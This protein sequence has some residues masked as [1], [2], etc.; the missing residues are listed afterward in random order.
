MISYD[1]WHAGEE[2]AEAGWR[3]VSRI[4]MTQPLRDYIFARVLEMTSKWMFR[5]TTP[6]VVWQMTHDERMLSAS[7]ACLLLP[8]LVMELVGGIFADR[9]DRQQIMTV[10]CIGSLACNLVIAALA[11]AGSL[12]LPLL[13]GLTALYGGINAVSHAAS[14]TIVTAYVR[15]EDLSTAVSLNAVV[16]NVAGFVGPALA[17]GLI[18]WFGS[19]ASYLTCAVLTSAF[20]LLLRRIPP[21][22]GEGGG[23]HGT[24]LGA[25]RDGL[26]HVLS[27]QLLMWVFILHIGSIALTRPFVE[28]VPAIVHHAFNG[29]VRESGI[30][31]S[32]F[33]LGS[34]AG[35]LWLAGSATSS[36]RLAAI[37]LGAMPVFAGA[38]IG[39]VL[40]PT[41]LMALPFAFVAGFGMISRA[42]A[43]QSL[44]QLESNPAYRGRIMSL[45]GVSFEIGCITGALFIGQMAK[46]LS[47]AV[48]LTTCVALLLVLWLAI[49]RPLMAAAEVAPSTQG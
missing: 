22:A 28:F 39:I 11:L 5:V 47:M 9:Y 6:M 2:P 48:A 3:R 23:H 45:H 43:I 1:L 40:S 10:S 17:A 34:I 31:L 25:L 44:L 7:L 46:S 35:G 14:K 16:F 29:G 37:V 41:L 15:K 13:L 33:G 19:A 18:Y 36:T 32:A 21:P 8:G 42:G 24:F 4:A 27:I 26:G 20:V 12:S 38:L 49:R 30:L